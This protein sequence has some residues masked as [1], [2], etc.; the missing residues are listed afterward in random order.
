MVD[1]IATSTDLRVKNK[2]EKQDEIEVSDEEEVGG[3]VNSQRRRSTKKIFP[4]PV[5]PSMPKS[6]DKLTKQAVRCC[7]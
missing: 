5:L 7:C 4:E 1:P 3:L 2:L 6:G